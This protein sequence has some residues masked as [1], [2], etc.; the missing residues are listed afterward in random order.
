[1]FPIE[2]FDSP[3][4]HDSQR[5]VENQFKAQH[6]R[7]RHH[8]QPAMEI[9]ASASAT[10]QMMNGWW[11]SGRFCSP[12][13]IALILNVREQVVIL[14]AITGMPGSYTSSFCHSKERFNIRKRR[15]EAKRKV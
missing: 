15:K 11:C 13:H 3:A 4:A 12:E 2:T 10:G 1:V 8:I 9:H 14:L 5:C 7:I 6:N